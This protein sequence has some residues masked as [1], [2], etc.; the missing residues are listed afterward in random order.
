MLFGEKCGGLAVARRETDAR[1]LVYLGGAGIGQSRLQ[2]KVICRGEAHKGRF[3]EI[4]FLQ[5]F[6]YQIAR[7][8]ET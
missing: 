6:E 8:P 2:G 4:V 3:G 5:K 7:A 1:L